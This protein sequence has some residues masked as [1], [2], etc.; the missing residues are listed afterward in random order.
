MLRLRPASSKKNALSRALLET[1]EL[2]RPAFADERVYTRVRQ[3]MFASLAT[4][5]RHTISAVIEAAGR[6]QLDWSGDYRVFSRD[7]WTAAELFGCL[8]PQV[9]SLQPSV[10]TVCAALDDTNIKKTGTHIPGVAYRR[11]PMSPAF[12]TNLVRAQR[13]VQTSMLVPLQT[14]P[15]GAR[16]IPIGFDHAPSA[17]KLPRNASDVEKR[18]HRKVQ[19]E[20]ALSRYA[21]ASIGR[22]R[23]TLDT[24]GSPDKK[25]LMTVDGSYTNR[26]V[27][28]GLPERTHIIGRIRKDAALH[29]L[30]GNSFRRGRP[31]SY[32][33]PLTPEGVRQDESIPWKSV[34]VFAAGKTHDC[35]IK[36][37]T[38]VLWRKTGPDRPQRLIVVRPLAY[39]KSNKSCLLYRQPAYLITTDLETPLPELLQAFF[40]RWD[41]EVNHRDEKQLLGVGHAQVRCPRSAERAP[42]FAVICYSALLI[43]AAR[44]FGLAGT[45]PVVEQPKWRREK[46]TKTT[47]LSTQQLLRRFAMENE[48]SP[49]AALNFSDFAPNVAR[50]TK[51]PKLSVSFSDALKIAFT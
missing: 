45:A 41:I 1:I 43:A 39:R 46:S 11:D 38:P 14:G 17:R 49:I 8:L 7:S 24:S 19:E 25:L 44:A 6:A 50:S 40:W 20:H 4:G 27:I 31:L 18:E 28:R 26:K 47:R 23:K 42:A 51:S 10:G 21:I 9:V 29:Q 15:S 33:D 5:Q 12:H 22:L 2:L 34:K 30:P 16:A 36:E 32:G 3:L 35:D 37:I 13:F 48:Q